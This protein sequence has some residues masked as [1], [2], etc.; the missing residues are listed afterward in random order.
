MRFFLIVFLFSY[1]LSS[2]AQDTLYVYA[3]SG[4]VL[5]AGGSPTSEKISVVPFGAEVVLTGIYSDTV[6]VQVLPSVS[7]PEG[8]SITESLPYVMCDVYR[9]V[10]YNGQKGFIY[11][12]YLSRYSPRMKEGAESASAAWL[13]ARPGPLDTLVDGRNKASELRLLLHAG[14]DICYRQGYVDGGTSESIILPAGSLTEGFLLANQLYNLEEYTNWEDQ[15]LEGH[16]DSLYLLSSVSE[17]H[18]E[19]S[20]YN[21]VVTITRVNGM[22]IIYQ[23]WSC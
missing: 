20:G 12:G 7:T 8:E 3:E 4:L 18:L 22:I 1:A 21:G 16:Y 9:E 14:N 19:F 13:S 5:R 15:T 11:G 10:E 2:S 23:D 17:N 6:E